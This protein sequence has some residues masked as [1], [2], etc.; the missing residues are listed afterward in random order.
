MDDEAGEETHARFSCGR[1]L[2]LSPC[3]LCYNKN[4]PFCA[5]EGHSKNLYLCMSALIAC[6]CVCPCTCSIPSTHILVFLPL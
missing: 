6:Q 1:A 2:T 3:C 4:A 5:S